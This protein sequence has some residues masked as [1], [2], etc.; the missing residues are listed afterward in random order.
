MTELLIEI[1]IAVVIML[2]GSTAAMH[3]L[4]RRKSNRRCGSC[5]RWNLE[6]GQSVMMQHGDF[7]NA[8]AVLAP[9]QMGATVTYEEDES[10]KL[11]E[12]PDGSLVRHE[13]RPDI[14][15]SARWSDFGL[16]QCECPIHHASVLT[17]R[18]D[19]CDHWQPHGGLIPVRSII[20]GGA[21]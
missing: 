4:A 18:D 6:D 1:L 15:L 17:F 13:D 10:G 20:R 21:R 16:C 19:A 2:G 8:A 7:M 3:A 12:N 11:K 14:P 5:R 9:S